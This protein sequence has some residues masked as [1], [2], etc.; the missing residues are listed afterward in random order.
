MEFGNNRIGGGSALHHGC[1]LKCLHEV[2]ITG[3]HLN[4]PRGSAT[5]G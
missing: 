5:S 1:S 4:G 2:V 3:G